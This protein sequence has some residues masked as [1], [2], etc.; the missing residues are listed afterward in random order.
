MQVG[1]LDLQEGRKRYTRNREEDEVDAQMCPCGKAIESETHILEECEKCKEERDV[2]EEEIKKVDEC[3]ME[4]FGTLDSSE[5]A[6]AI[7]GDIDGGHR[8][9]NRKGIR[10]AKQF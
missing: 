4:E 2:F 3:D 9:R 1:D 5:K 10:L 7:L 6:I 8:R